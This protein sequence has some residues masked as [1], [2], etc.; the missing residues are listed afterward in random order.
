MLSNFEKDLVDLDFGD[1]GFFNDIRSHES[2][3]DFF[4]TTAVFIGKSM[5]VSTRGDAVPCAGGVRQRHHGIMT[6]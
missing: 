3:E 4:Q 1:W 5:E 6:E 2:H